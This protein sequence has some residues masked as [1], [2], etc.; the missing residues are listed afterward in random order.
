M[1]NPFERKIVEWKWTTGEIYAK[2]RR[3]PK[4]QQPISEEEYV[5][6]A[7]SQRIENSAY[8]SSLNHDENT[9]DILN[10]SVVFRN[11][12]KREDLDFKIADRELI[13]QCGFNPFN[14]GRNF[15]DD[16]AKQSNPLSTSYGRQQ[17]EN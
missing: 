9:W 12:N 15:A 2:S 1:S 7:F 10:Q 8:N 17:G 11:S 6:P 5:D 13:Q 16:I 4:N 14:P 3:P